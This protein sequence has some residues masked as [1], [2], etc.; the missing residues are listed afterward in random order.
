MMVSNSRSPCAVGG[1]NPWAEEN[2]KGV[3]VGGRE[4]DDK[5]KKTSKAPEPIRRQRN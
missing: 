4:F 5:K 2:C 3:T 1:G